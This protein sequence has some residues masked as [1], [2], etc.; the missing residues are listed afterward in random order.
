MIKFDAS[1]LHTDTVLV[2]SCSTS[3][4]GYIQVV[5]EDAT[6]RM[7]KEI[8][9]TIA[10]PRWVAFNFI[11][12]NGQTS[13]FMTARPVKV[14][15]YDKLVIDLEDMQVTDHIVTDNAIV[16]KKSLKSESFIERA[17]QRIHN[18]VGTSNDQWYIDG[19][20]IY[21]FD[22]T[23]EPK[24]LSADNKFRCLTVNAIDLTHMHLE[25]TRT[26]EDPMNETFRAC[27][28][29][30]ASNGMVAISPPEWSSYYSFTA[31]SIKSAYAEDK[32]TGLPFDILN[33]LYGVN[34][35][36][37]L[38]AAKV[39]SNLFDFDAIEPLNLPELMLE[40]NTVN[41]PN[42]NVDI[43][44]TFDIGL[45]MSHTM[46]WL[47]G[48]MSKVDNIHDYIEMATVLKTL[49]GNG[50]FRKSLVT[51]S[52]ILK[53]G[54]DFSDIVVKTLEDAKAIEVTTAMQV[55]AWRV[56]NTKVE[57]IEGFS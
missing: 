28:G 4:G 51:E 6:A 46:A 47:L 12:S 25:R 52:A 24:P 11:R 22:N 34:I 21:R 16:V 19:V 40:L 7:K 9:Y 23:A 42:I 27:V 54:K 3:N 45:K 36:F 50:I 53:S 37:A 2:K 1:L 48:L 10:V 18:V 55:A 29:F 49:T 43:K 8:Y 14:C 20:Y 33:E 5:D 35:T 38:R 30:Y 15:Y 44:A 13:K 41:I 32:A 39:I 56:N 31:A 17:I 57:E 26:G